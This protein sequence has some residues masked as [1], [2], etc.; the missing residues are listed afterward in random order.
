MNYLSAIDLK[1]LVLEQAERCVSLYL[2]TDPLGRDIPR[3]QLRLRNLAREAE[4]HLLTLGARAPEV[5]A[6][7]Q[8]IHDLLADSF[9]WRHLG[10]GLAVFRSPRVFHAFCL[11][12]SFEPRWVVAHR[13]HI[14]PLLPLLSQ[15]ITFYV[16]ALS[17]KA[18]RLFRGTPEALTE[19]QL[20]HLPHSVAE[21]LR[22]D[23]PD[24]EVRV[25]AAGSVA[26]TRRTGI[27]YGSGGGAEAYKD[28]LAQFCR[29]IESG[30]REW[31]EAEQ[32]PLVLAGVDYVVALYREVNRYPRLMDGEII[33]NPDRLGPEA[34]HTQAWQVLQPYLRRKQAEA[35]AVYHNLA[36]TR[37]VS[38]DVRHVVPAAYAGQVQTLFVAV[39]RE[40]WGQFDPATQS[41]HLWEAP[42]PEMDDL[43]DLAAVQTLLTGG[44]VYA[45]PIREM[46][47]EAP[48]AAVLRY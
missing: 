5:K 30:V 37:R 35:V 28:E 29:Q 8:P 10:H 27:F 17:Q 15:A 42:S 21:A 41:L 9:F 14:K 16:L 44:A 48:L 47:D 39:D 4:S 6:L 13:F 7:W 38:S 31:L 33:G 43:L 1:A 26:G 46:P 32:A 40:Q 2:P 24:K 11:P 18:V 22:I 25:R 19:I 3:D 36:G 20:D 45:V 34:L 23:T 12:L